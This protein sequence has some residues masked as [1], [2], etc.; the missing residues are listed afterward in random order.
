MRPL[1]LEQPS[2]RGAVLLVVIAAI[3][4]AGVGLTTLATEA[5]R[6]TQAAKAAIES[7]QRRWGERTV[8]DVLLA[9]APKL[10]ETHA[11]RR[12]ASQ[13]AHRVRVSIP[14]GRSRF[15]VVVADEAAKANLNHIA[16]YAGLSD[17]EQAIDDLAEDAAPFVNLTPSRTPLWPQS[18][19]DP[20]PPPTFAGWGEVFD[21]A[22]IRQ[23]TGDARMLAAYTG[24]IT[25]LSRGP[26]NVARAPEETT[27]AVVAAITTKARAVSIVAQLRRSNNAVD[28]KLLVGSGPQSDRLL[29]A[30]T[31]TSQTYSVW[32]ESSAASLRTQLFRSRLVGDDGTVREVRLRL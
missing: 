6:Q 28:L 20:Q 18:P 22:S 30:L 26:L 5:L 24:D 13:P 1:Q 31:T 9:A 21:V 11:T 2:R 27:R 7:V 32:I 10:I 25:L 16:Q 19:E 12:D 8:G 15:D 14:L 23:T 4:V 3:V 17:V 29:D